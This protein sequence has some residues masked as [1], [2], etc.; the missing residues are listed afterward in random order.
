MFRC[1]IV[2]CVCLQVSV[3]S[4]VAEVSS[5]TET[6]FTVHHELTMTADKSE[7]YRHLG[8]IATWWSPSHTWTGKAENL[9][10][11]LQPGGLFLETLPDGGFVE[12]QRVVYVAPE[13]L[14]RL[15]GALGPL[16]EYA[17]TGTLTISMTQKGDEPTRLTVDY[18]VS[19][20]LP[21]G[22]AQ[23]AA[24][25]DQVIGEQFTR[26]KAVAESQDQ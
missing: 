24:V 5:K 1:M 21:G 16:Q 14:V 7:V 22:P 2:T 8:Q 9:S 12:H 18:R 10:L 25:V 4:T 6:G 15:T 20:E 17:V 26:L 23:W 3:N 11:N 19:G 13:R